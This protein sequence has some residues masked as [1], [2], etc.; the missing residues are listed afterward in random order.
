MRLH[1][2]SSKLGVKRVLSLYGV[3]SGVRMALSYT[4]IR[5]S[6]GDWN[7][8]CLYTLSETFDS[9][10]HTS[11]VP[12]GFVWKCENAENVRVAYSFFRHLNTNVRPGIN[13]NMAST[14]RARL[15]RVFT[16]SFALS[17]KK[18]L[19]AT[20]CSLRVLV[21]SGSKLHLPFYHLHMYIYTIYYIHSSSVHIVHTAD[22]PRR[23]RQYALHL[24]IDI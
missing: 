14:Q 24:S 1:A 23:T 17:C 6:C 4:D 10:T 22:R 7:V 3:H 5:M 2:Y 9:L 16:Y 8:F 12:F 21:L 19:Q 18:Q 11:T 13:T 20:T 15:H